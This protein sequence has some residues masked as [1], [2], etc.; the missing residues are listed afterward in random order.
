MSSKQA[1]LTLLAIG[2]SCSAVYDRW[3]LTDKCISSGPSSSRASQPRATSQL[4]ALSRSVA[5]ATA[6]SAPPST[7][8]DA[9]SD[10]ISE[11]HLKKKRR[12]QSFILPQ[13]DTNRYSLSC[14]FLELSSLFTSPFHPT[15]SLNEGVLLSRER[16]EG[17][18]GEGQQL[19]NSSGSNKASTSLL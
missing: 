9:E 13:H 1:V 6:I 2:S 3:L 15:L 5:L 19:G 12:L 17:R 4:S 14:Q 18:G 7:E 10:K 11:G 16:E 8:H